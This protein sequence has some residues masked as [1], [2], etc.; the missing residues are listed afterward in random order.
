MA[1]I[2]KDT[3]IGEALRANPDIAPVLMDRYALSWMPFC[4][5]RDVGRGSYGTWDRSGRFDG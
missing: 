4:T 3:T 5:G 2:T 1:D